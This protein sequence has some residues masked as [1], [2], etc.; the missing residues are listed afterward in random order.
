MKAGDF[1]EE[2]KTVLALGELTEPLQM[3]EMAEEVDW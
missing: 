1:S 3:S 2:L